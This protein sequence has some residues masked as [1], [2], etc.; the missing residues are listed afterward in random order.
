MNVKRTELLK[1]LKQCLPGIESGN[2]V[3]EGADLFIFRDGFVHSYNDMISVSVPVKSDGLLENDIAGAVRA[4]EFY[5]IINKFT[6]ELIAF[7]VQKDRWVLKSGKAKA[8]LVLMAGDY[9]DRFEN[10]KPEKKK[11][12]ELPTEFMTG[13]G[14]CRMTGNK[15][16]ISGLFIT[17]KDITSSDGYQINNYRYQGPAVDNFWISDASAGELLKVGA[18]SHIQVKENWAHFRTKDNTVFSVKTLQAEKWPYEKLMAV[19]AGSKKSKTDFS[20]K[21]PKELFDAIDRA[22]AFYMDISDSRAVRLELSAKS[23]KVSAEKAAG[24]YQE[25]VDWKEPPVEFT[26]FELYVD[27]NMMVFAGRRSMSFYIH[28]ASGEEPRLVFITEASTHLMS[29][30]NKGDIADPAEKAK[31]EKPAKGKAVAKTDAK[32]TKGKAKPAQESDEDEDDD[33]PPWQEPAKGKGKASTK[34]E[35]GK[36]TGT[37]EPV[38]EDDDEDDEPPAKPAKGKAKTKPAPEPEEDEEEEDDESDEEDDDDVDLDLDDDEDED[39][40]DQE[41]EDEDDE[42]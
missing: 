25:K 19:M 26:S 14:I 34:K 41:D 15:N 5:G 6:G 32:P 30:L 24:N 37:T 39:A 13:L 38:Y 36:K 31:E 10:I 28:E 27:T 2:S 22:A 8:E 12:L 40:D 20:A 11:W 4:E 18:L 17:D 3:L 21:F 1:A 7:E 16:P 33:T 9:S 42:E 29:T 35:V 23:I